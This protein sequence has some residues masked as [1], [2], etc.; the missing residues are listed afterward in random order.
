LA[1][2][3]GI[4][5]DCAPAERARNKDSIGRRTIDRVPESK[6]ENRAEIIMARVQSTLAIRNGTLVRMEKN[7]LAV[8]CNFALMGLSPMLRICSSGR[9]TGSLETEPLESQWGDQWKVT[10]L[11]DHNALW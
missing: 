7:G 5:A 8:T 4:W 3:I 2:E 6:I 9:K 10:P 11:S 1:C